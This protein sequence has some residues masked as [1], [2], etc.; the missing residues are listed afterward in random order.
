[1]PRKPAPTFEGKPCKVCGSTTRYKSSTHACVA[2]AQA[3]A[4][5]PEHRAATKHW[6]RNTEEGREA[7]RRGNR[8]RYLK[9]RE[10]V[11]ARDKV[12]CRWRKGYIPKPTDCICAHCG[13]PAEEYH[14]EDY[15]KPL[16]V[17]PLCKPCH[18]KHHAA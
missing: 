16:D 3:R 17:I 18:I 5:K 8:I 15:S 14:H 2:C 1:M 10:K 4:A 12:R 9:D 6:L 13:V 7:V 11:L